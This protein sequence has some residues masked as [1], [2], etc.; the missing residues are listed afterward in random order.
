MSENPGGAT[1][2]FPWV[3]APLV[4]SATLKQEIGLVK[5]KWVLSW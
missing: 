5:D 2:G 1:L 3:L 4:G